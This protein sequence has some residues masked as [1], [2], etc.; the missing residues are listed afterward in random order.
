MTWRCLINRL[1]DRKNWLD[2]T[3]MLV[4]RRETCLESMKPGGIPAGSSIGGT[5][6]ENYRKVARSWLE[7]CRELPICPLHRVSLRVCR[8]DTGEPI[9]SM[10][11]LFMLFL[12]PFPSFLFSF[13]FV[14][15]P[16]QGSFNQAGVIEHSIV[17]SK[18][19]I[20]RTYLDI[21]W[22]IWRRWEYLMLRNEKR[23]EETRKLFSQSSTN[24]L[25]PSIEEF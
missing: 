4:S 14:F 9:M 23:N 3:T 2:R 13:D 7:D 21:C 19:K 17:H 15:A 25:L 1:N 18:F 11:T 5:M 10:D 20:P 24:W 6:L 12:F 16:F 22:N 8:L